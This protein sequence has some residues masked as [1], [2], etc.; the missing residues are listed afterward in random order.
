MRLKLGYKKKLE[1]YV[2]AV[3]FLIGVFFA[4]HASHIK[5]FLMD[6]VG[7]RALPLTLSALLIIGSSSILL[8]AI[9]GHVGEVQEGYGF[10]DS[11]IKPINSV[12]SSGVIYVVCFWAFGYFL[13]TF[14]AVG[15][16][17]IS[18][19]HTNIIKIMLFSIAAS[20][21]YQF[22]FMGMM[23]LYDPAGEVLDLRRYTN[24]I[25]GA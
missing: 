5:P 12:I 18:F 15:L 25:I 2:A 10:Q 20:L 11:N 22:I 14:I 16:I 4:Y 13:A 9:L 21:I 6:V 19:G 8:R 24:W 3:V 7:P 23:G 17:M 1:A